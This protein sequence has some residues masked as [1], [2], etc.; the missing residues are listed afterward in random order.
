M[1]AV[2]A[3]E[4]AGADAQTPGSFG[5]FDD[6]GLLLRNATTGRLLFF[7]DNHQ[8]VYTLENYGF[9]G[10][11]DRVHVSGNHSPYYVCANNTRCIQSNSISRGCS[12]PCSGIAGDA[13]N[14]GKINVA[15]LSV[16]IRYIFKGGAGGIS[17]CDNQADCNRNGRVEM[18]DVSCIIEMVF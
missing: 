9:F 2:V 6:C 14:D 12:L 7:P 8:G 11:G 15:D 5:N 13:T 1:C 16:L 18:G 10:D 17:N 4:S 3:G